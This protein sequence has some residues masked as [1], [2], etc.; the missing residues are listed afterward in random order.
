M[1]SYLRET[2]HA[3]SL[4]I[5]VLPHTGASRYHNCCID[6]GTSP[7]NFGSTHVQQGMFPLSLFV[8]NIHFAPVAPCPLIMLVLYPYICHY[9]NYIVPAACMYDFAFMGFVISFPNFFVWDFCTFVSIGWMLKRVFSFGHVCL[10]WFCIQFSEVADSSRSCRI[11]LPNQTP[12]KSILKSSLFSPQ[13]PTTTSVNNDDTTA[14][15]ENFYNLTNST[16][17]HD[18]KGILTVITGEFQF[19]EMLLWQLNIMV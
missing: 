8:M 15:G 6:G 2:W 12:K 18:E 13:K 5:V 14:N 7:E 17:F 19:Q 1:S 9:A 10:F 11:P 3:D 16:K 4:N